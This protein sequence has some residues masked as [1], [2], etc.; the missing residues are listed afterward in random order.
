L[1]EAA[2]NGH[3]DTVKLLLE[4]GA[5]PNIRKADGA[6]A[7]A[8]ATGQKHQ[9]IVDLLNEAITRAAQAAPSP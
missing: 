9:D 5:N 3:T 4:N 2:W 6:T 7:V 1:T 8:L